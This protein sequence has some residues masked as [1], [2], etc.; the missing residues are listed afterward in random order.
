[1][2]Q[3]AL[4]TCFCARSTASPQALASPF[5]SAVRASSRATFA[6]IALSPPSPASADFSG[7][8]AS[9]EA[10]GPDRFVYRFELP[11]LPLAG[12]ELVVGE[13]HLTDDLRR[14]AGLVLDD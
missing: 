8:A 5:L 11:G 9:A 6:C 14:I 12:S 2:P 1:M 3:G 7:A 13:Q 4:S 10:P